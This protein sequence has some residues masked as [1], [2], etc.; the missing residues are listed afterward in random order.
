[1]RVRVREGGIVLECVVNVSEGRDA[2]VLGALAEAAGPALLDVHT[3]PHHHRSVFTLAGAEVMDATRS[4]TA[5]AVAR[6]DLRVHAGVHPRIGVVDVVPFVALAGSS[7]ADA[8]RARDDLARWAGTELGVPCFVYGPE[9][10]LPDVR[11]QAFRGLAPDTGPP[12]PHPTAGAAAVGARGVLV[13]FNVWLAPGT[14]EVVAAR[15]AEA[16][17]S[18]AVRALGLDVGGR[19]QVSCNLVDPL[20]TGPA[21]A[22]DAVTV[23]ARH[24]GARVDGAELVGLVP[25][26]VLAA[27]DPARWPALD[28]DPS[29]T[30]EARLERAG[31]VP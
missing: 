18:P 14:G 2:V 1:M 29:R 27:I 3:D 8:V 10:S 15:V 11:R 16:V 20:G 23:A 17:R 19:A 4:L 21:A 13:A 6:L 12:L 25:A 7:P 30:I 24:L 9:R 22:F 26:G 28:L 5:A 31:L